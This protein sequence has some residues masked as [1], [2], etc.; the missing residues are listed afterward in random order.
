MNKRGTVS[1][2]FA[3]SVPMALVA[4]V[5]AIDAVRIWLEQA[6]LQ[7]ALDAAALTAARDMDSPDMHKNTRA[8]LAANNVNA[9][10]IT[11]TP[12]ADRN[13]V[14][15]SASVGVVPTVAR[16]AGLAGWGEIE[17]PSVNI[18]RSADADRTMSGIELALAFDI[19]LSMV[20]NDGSS[21]KNRIQSARDAALRMLTILYGD[22]PDK[23]TDNKK[24]LNNLFISVTPFNVAVNYGKENSHFL[25]APPPLSGSSEYPV[26]WTGTVTGWGGCAEMRSPS[27]LDANS[28]SAGNGLRRYYWASTYDAA[29]KYDPNKSNNASNQPFCLSNAAYRDNR[30]GNPSGANNVCMG[31][32]DWTAPPILL[33]GT[34][35]VSSRQNTLISSFASN[36]TVTAAGVNAWTSAHGP[37]MMCPPDSGDRLTNLTVLPLTRDRET[38]EARIKALATLPFSWGT[39]IASGLQ[40]AWFTLSPKW[41][42]GD[43][44]LGWTFKEPLDPGNTR[45]T[46][47]S[48]PLNYYAENMS[49]VLILLTDGDNNWSSAR[50]I[51]GS[52]NGLVRPESR[53]ISSFYGG[54]G[55]LGPDY[56]GDDRPS[57]PT[58]ATTPSNVGTASTNAISTAEGLMDDD[59]EAWCAKIK[60][61]VSTGDP[62]KVTIYTIGF[63]SGIGSR[64]TAVL[65]NCASVGADGKRLYYRATDGEELDKI[66]TAIGNNL[67]RLRLTR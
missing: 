24:Y 5:F 26:S 22:N 12:S 28:V 64:A 8:V 6:R 67:A 40:G 20:A 61:G 7:T 48:L 1:I 2:L 10:N 52:S 49:K 42:R 31:H 66:F 23:P 34:T 35:G 39:N 16:I 17:M 36:S 13:K 19:T 54:Y 50:E 21:G 47:P 57:V 3:A 30:V 41:R 37:N 9:K 65:T 18:V 43:G 27:L 25:D 45:G 56:T 62:E 55:K 63:G 53:E 4:G 58:P 14:T 59:A 46:M 15:V 29:Q 38:V 60:A 44:F 32:N 51:Q 33:N 11:V